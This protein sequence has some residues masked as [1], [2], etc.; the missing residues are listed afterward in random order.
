MAILGSQNSIGV[1]QNDELFDKINT[2][3]NWSFKIIP[4]CYNC[5]FFYSHIIT[6]N[7]KILEFGIKH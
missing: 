4:Y 7:K 6:Q 3:G 2:K 5:D 1:L